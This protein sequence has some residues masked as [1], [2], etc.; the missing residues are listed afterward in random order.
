MNQK[1]Y[2]HSATHNQDSAESAAIKAQVQLRL[3][4][5]QRKRWLSM[6]FVLLS[7]AGIISAGLF[8][9]EDSLLYFRVPSD[10]L[11]SPP[12]SDERMRLGGVVEEGSI[13][14][15]EQGRWQFRVGDGEA[16]MGVYFSGV[17]PDLF[18]EGQGMI[19]EGYYREGIFWADIVLAK[20]D[21][22]YTPR[23]LRGENLLEAGYGE[24][25]Q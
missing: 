23:S 4:K 18:Q 14:F 9:L 15:T 17:L 22:N 11:A 8:V 19:A 5:H 12:K 10:V 3:R 7:C 21:E 2:T 16:F 13:L 20:H 25:V 1:S 24:Q 6:F